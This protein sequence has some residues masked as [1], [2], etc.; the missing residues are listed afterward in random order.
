MC[1]S[2]PGIFNLENAMVVGDR[3][4]AFHRG[5]G[6]RAHTSASPVGPAAFSHWSLGLRDKGVGRGKALSE[7]QFPRL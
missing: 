1:P 5:G 2:L 7:L 4:G 3:E 6:V